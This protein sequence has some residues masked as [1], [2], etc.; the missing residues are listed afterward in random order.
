MMDI[1][2]GPQEP[3]SETQEF[4]TL[5][6]KFSAI[7]DAFANSRYLE[8]GNHYSGDIPLNDE[9]KIMATH[10]VALTLFLIERSSFKEISNLD[11]SRNLGINAIGFL[12]SRIVPRREDEESSLPMTAGPRTEKDEKAVFNSYV[13]APAKR[14]LEVLLTKNDLS[15]TSTRDLYALT[16]KC[17][18]VIDAIVA[19]KDNIGLNINRDMLDKIYE[20]LFKVEHPLFEGLKT[21][22]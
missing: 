16:S 3:R 9:A 14:F 1:E 21:V 19:N 22:E 5:L 10:T 2:R 20:H 15:L 8:M 12:V 4:S 11:K 13:L 18:T 17:S 6:N 7:V